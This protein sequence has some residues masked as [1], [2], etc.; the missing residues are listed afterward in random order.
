[1]SI[2][3]Q[4]NASNYILNIV[5]LQNVVNNAAG[6]TPLDVLSNT[7]NNLQEMVNYDLKRINVNTIAR[8]DQTPIQIIDDINLSNATLFQNGNVV[9]SGTVGNGGQTARTLSLGSTSIILNSTVTTGNYM[10]FNVNGATAMAI[11]SN[12]NIVT[13]NTFVIG[14]S[15]GDLG[16]SLMCLDTLGTSAWG[17][18]STLATS[19]TIRFLGAGGEV[20]RFTSSSN[21]GIGKNAPVRALDV[22]GDGYFTGIVSAFNYVTL[23][24]IR[25][26]SN[27]TRIENG[28]DILNKISGVRF[29]WNETGKNDIGVIAQDL[30]DVLPEAVIEDA[31][32]LNVAYH[33][34]IPVLIEVIKEQNARINFLEKIV[35]V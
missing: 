7:V 23:S 28:Q 6:L 8:F 33:K 30:L 19:D 20:A 25:Y 5:E 29:Q 18:V 24:D 35:L 32:K 27:I 21:L 4:L 17:N 14:N 34:L 9:A 26:K 11:T 12:T 22:V 2:N 10:S 16:K 13:S 1:M 31:D 15:S 3:P